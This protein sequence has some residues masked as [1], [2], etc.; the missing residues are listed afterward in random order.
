MALKKLRKTSL[1]KGGGLL[2]PSDLVEGSSDPNGKK[3]FA[4]AQQLSTA[5]TQEEVAAAF[6]ALST[7]ADEDLKRSN[8]AMVEQFGR[9]TGRYS[10]GI[11]S[12]LGSEGLV[13]SL[14][15]A[16][17]AKINEVFT[18]ASG[19]PGTDAITAD[20]EPSGAGAPSG[21]AGAG[22]GAGAPAGGPGTGAGADAGADMYG[23]SKK[24]PSK[25]PSKKASKKRSKKTSKTMKG[26]RKNVKKSS[27]KPASKK[28]ASKKPVSKKAGSKKS[29]KTMKGG[30]PKKS[31]SKKPVKKTSKKSGSKKMV[32]K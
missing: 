4:F 5:T 17:T 14:V 12:L 9:L 21:P 24:K 11:I 20:T 30:K 1:L 31:A 6:T 15:D 28:T 23:G 8:I 19:A 29:S 3:V 16:S 7:G 32:R 25:K 13:G 18:T 27:K 22:A 10:A 26:G 2:C